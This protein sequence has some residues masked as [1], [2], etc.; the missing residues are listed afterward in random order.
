MDG[1]VAEV[2]RTK[3]TRTSSASTRWLP[4]AFLKSPGVNINMYLD[5]DNWCSNLLLGLPRFAARFSVKSRSIVA[6]LATHTSLKGASPYEDAKDDYDDDFDEGEEDHD[7][8]DEQLSS[9][10]TESFL[11]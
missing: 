4:K 10:D 6:E 1:T 7:D 11:L 3:D 8:D 9:V 5:V 2:D